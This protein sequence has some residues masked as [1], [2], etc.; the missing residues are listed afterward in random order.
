MK[1]GLENHHFLLPVYLQISPKVADERINGRGRSEESTIQMQF[2]EHLN[3]AHEDWLIYGNATGVH[4]PAKRVWVVN[5]EHSFDQM[6]AI[7]KKLAEKIWSSIPQQ[8]KTPSN[9]VY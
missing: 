9:R 7:Y 3:R 2:L 8:L 4:V 5:T 6:K 1:I